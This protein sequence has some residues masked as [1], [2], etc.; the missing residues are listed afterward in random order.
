MQFDKLIKTFVDKET[1]KRTTE[2]E[3]SFRFTPTY[4]NPLGKAIAL[5]E[6]QRQELRS[7]VRDKVQV[8]V[9]ERL[10]RVISG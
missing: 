9:C 7:G 10:L 4:D 6:Q 1:N 3:E 8:E 5:T 2:L